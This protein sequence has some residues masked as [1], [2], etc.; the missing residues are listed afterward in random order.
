MKHF[1]TLYILMLTNTIA[2]AQIE[3]GSVVS[4][5]GG[6]FMIHEGKKNTSFKPTALVEN[7]FKQKTIN[8]GITAQGRYFVSNHWQIGIYLGYGMNRFS[9]KSS[10]T[11][12]ST[13]N[14]QRS[15][16]FIYKQTRQ[17]TSSYKAGP[18]L[19]FLS[20]S[21]FQ[22]SLFCQIVPYVF[23]YKT[24]LHYNNSIDESIESND[25]FSYGFLVQPAIWYSLSDRFILEFAPI[26]FNLERPIEKGATS[27]LSFKASFQAIS[28]TINYLVK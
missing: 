2:L 14:N 11:N 15:N 28:F 6:S 21:K 18:S 9:Q 10:Y 12:L 22:T 20:G 8:W 24:T 26:S 25:G 4:S 16:N 27:D 19:G 17:Y 1:W 7:Q 23:Y 13:N 3:Q 5:I